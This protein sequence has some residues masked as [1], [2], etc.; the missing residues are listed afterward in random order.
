MIRTLNTP[1]NLAK[2]IALTAGGGLNGVLGSVDSQPVGIL[3]YHRIVDRIV[4]VASPTWNVSPAALRAQLVGLLERGFQPCALRQLIE[5]H[6]CARELP[7]KSFVVTFDDGHESVYSHAWPIL[8]ELEIPATV[9]LTTAYLDSQRPFPFE[10]WSAAGSH[11][12]AIETWRPLSTE[13]C[14][15][16][17]ND[18]LVQLGAHTHTHADFRDRENE[19][20]YDLALNLEFLRS[21]LNVRHP[22]FAF[23]FGRVT[24]ALMAAVHRAGCTCGLTTVGTLVNPAQTPFGWGRFHVD[25]WDTAVTLAAKLNGWYSWLPWLR[26]K[27]AAGSASMAALAPTN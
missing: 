3:M 13:Q 6:R 22:P 18:G 15:D 10:D 23:P 9:F 14:L 26:T 25:P 24:P 20:E 19:F 27:W 1:K 2:R 8:K 21:R 11:Q 12:A 4:G 5:D 17:S 16:M 7:N